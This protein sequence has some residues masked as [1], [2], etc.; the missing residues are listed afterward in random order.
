M[1][2]SQKRKGQRGEREAAALLKSIW[3]DARRGISQSRGALEAD[4]EE[5]PCHVECKVGRRPNLRAALDQAQRDTDGR[6][7]LVIAKDDGAG[8]RPAAWRVVMTVADFRRLVEQERREAVSA[9]A[10]GIG[11]GR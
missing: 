1:G 3:P 8:A 4:I 6:P 5:T 10:A 9:A 2:L 11:V 7:C